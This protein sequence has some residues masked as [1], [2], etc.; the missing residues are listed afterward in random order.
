M[1]MI[2]Q[3]F[4]MW[5]FGLVGAMGLSPL[6]PQQHRQPSDVGRKIMNDCPID[7]T[8]S[9]ASLLVA[10]TVL[11][12]STYPLPAHG[13]TKQDVE[14]VIMASEARTNLKFKE[15]EEKILKGTDMKIREIDTK[16]TAISIVSPV[17]T[18]G[19]A[20]W[21]NRDSSN[22][23]DDTL[24]RFADQ[25]ENIKKELEADTTVKAINGSIAGSALTVVL[26]AIG[27]IGTMALVA[28]G[29]SIHSP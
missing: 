18:A 12:S 11:A 8:R 3:T 7:V 19:F 29:S 4:L 23:L 5:C 20:A 14:D 28:N 15:M 6:G 16:L 27:S 1:M 26:I 17:I 2:Y 21:S 13:L 9:T 10:I 24:K 22:K 25:R